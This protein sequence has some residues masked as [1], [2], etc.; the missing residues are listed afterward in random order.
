MN[1]LRVRFHRPYTGQSFT[2]EVLIVPRVGETVVRH[3]SSGST[4]WTVTKVTHDYE[5]RAFYR[6]DPEMSDCIHVTLEEVRK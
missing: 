4:I 3:L 1:K 6:E 2:R 5:D